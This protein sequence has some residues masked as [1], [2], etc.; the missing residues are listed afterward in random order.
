MHKVRENEHIFFNHYLIHLITP[1]FSGIFVFW[2]N[3]WAFLIMHTINNLSKR[4]IL[5]LG[6][7]VAM[8]LLISNIGNTVPMMENNLETLEVESI[9]LA[10][11]I[12]Q[13]MEN[14]NMAEIQRVKIFNDAGKLVYETRNTKDE[15]LVQLL[16][17]SDFLTQINNISYYKLSR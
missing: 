3:C 16:N 13:S 15:K 12:V 4:S 2:H 14:M 7:L 1:L 17:K 5:I 6:I 11:H 8:G 9:Q 10:K